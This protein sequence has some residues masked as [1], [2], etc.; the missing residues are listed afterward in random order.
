M[1][2]LEREGLAFIK[3]EIIRSSHLEMD[4]G[5]QGGW[6][7]RSLIPVGR[8]HMPPLE[9]GLDYEGVLEPTDDA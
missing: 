2:F 1:S 6:F 9:D 3:A 8:M 7:Y 4:L 5:L